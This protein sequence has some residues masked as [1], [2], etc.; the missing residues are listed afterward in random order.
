MSAE[1]VIL[2]GRAFNEAL[3]T[4]ACTITR[5]DATPVLNETTGHYDVT[6]TTI[7]TGPC[8]IRFVSTVVSEADAQAQLLVE[9]NAILS[10]PIVGSE[11]VDVDD[12]ATITSSY[13]DGA[14][15]GKV[16]RITGIHAQS[17]AT[18]RRLTV[19]IIS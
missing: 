6:S 1:S 10:L 4:S 7:Y 19:E 18:A 12:L 13:M 9:Q 17:F 8:K 5:G 15:V 3:M 16:F 2:Q 11:T 14:L